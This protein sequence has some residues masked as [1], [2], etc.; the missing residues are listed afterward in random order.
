[1]VKNLAQTIKVYLKINL[2]VYKKQVKLKI[3]LIV[4]YYQI[5]IN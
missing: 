2:V 3:K 4:K 5:R 1:M